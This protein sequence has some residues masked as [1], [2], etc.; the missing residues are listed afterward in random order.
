MWQATLKILTNARGLRLKSAK[1]GAPWN[2]R[3]ISLQT[4]HRALSEGAPFAR[5]LRSLACRWK[6]AMRW[7]RA[8]SSA[9]LQINQFAQSRVRLDLLRNC[10]ASRRSA[11]SGV[12]CR[13]LFCDLTSQPAEAALAWSIFF[14]AGGS[15]KIYVAHLEKARVLLGVST[16]WK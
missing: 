14:G 13:A 7:A 8:L 16:A 15:F 1:A 6:T 5:K 4:Q 10:E 11:A 12:R 9:G 2:W 3:R